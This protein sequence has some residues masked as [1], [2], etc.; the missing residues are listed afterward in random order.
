MSVEGCS[1]CTAPQN[2][3]ITPD[4]ISRPVC[5]Y[6]EVQRLAQGPDKCGRAGRWFEPL[7]E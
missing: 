5:E 2:Q 4:G 6:C 7:D 1:H 3:G